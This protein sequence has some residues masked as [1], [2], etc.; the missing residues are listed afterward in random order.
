LLPHERSLA[1][2]DELEEERRLAFV[3]MTRAKE[4]L[5]LCHSRLREFR[6]QT[7]YAVPSMFLDELP[8]EGV[9]STDLS[10][11]G[12]KKP[13]PSDAWRGGS[14]AS[15]QGWHDAGIPMRGSPALETRSPPTPGQTY[16]EGMLVRHEM[17]G[18]GQVIHVGGHGAMRRV[19]IRF[20]T[21]GERTFVADKARL[22]IVGN[23]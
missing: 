16:A 7:L 6:G 17:Y 21:G 12:T 8:Q 18:T 19:K 9:Q 23:G 3:G 13:R 10:Y 1:K 5:Y 15:A 22:V 4:E 2:D 11:S 20:K 14:S